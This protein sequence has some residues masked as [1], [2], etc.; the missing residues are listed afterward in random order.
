MSIQR[1]EIVKGGKRVD[2]KDRIISSFAKNACKKIAGKVIRKMQRITE[3][4]LSGD[5]TPLKNAWDEVCVQVQGEESFCW[6][7]YMEQMHIYIKDELKELSLE[8]KQAIWLQTEEGWEWAYEENECEEEAIDED[9][10]AQYILNEHIL[11]EVG[12]Y[13]N[14]RIEK[15]LWEE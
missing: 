11:T 5:D 1:K 6:D 13:S 4:L 8:T 7:I 10:I 2:Y 12:N 3:E 14:I 15:Y 9:D